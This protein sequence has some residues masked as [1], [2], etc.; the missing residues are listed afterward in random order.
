MK[1]LYLFCW[2]TA[3]VTHHFGYIAWGWRLRQIISH[4][5]ENESSLHALIDCLARGNPDRF[6]NTTS[7]SFVKS[8]FQSL[9]TLLIQFSKCMEVRCYFS[10]A[11]VSWIGTSAMWP[12]CKIPLCRLSH[13]AECFRPCVLLFLELFNLGIPLS[14]QVFLWR[15][16]RVDAHQTLLLSMFTGSLNERELR[17][18]ASLFGSLSSVP[19]FSRFAGLSM[20][21]SV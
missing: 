16:C 13:A 18:L 20:Q 19:I 14:L 9:R 2:R 3:L 11:C 15:N 17:T 6:I 8:R 7:G 5:H 4:T 21:S 1:T 10:S 12:T